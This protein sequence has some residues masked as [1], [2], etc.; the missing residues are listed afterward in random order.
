MM[1]HTNSRQ[2]ERYLLAGYSDN[3]TG[4]KSYFKREVKTDMSK[5]KAQL[6][7]IGMSEE[8]AN[9]MILKIEKKI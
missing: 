8:D 9:E 4:D 6:L 3:I 2:T 7:E 1:A 5:M